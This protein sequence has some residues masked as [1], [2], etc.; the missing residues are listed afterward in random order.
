MQAADLCNTAGGGEL[1]SRGGGVVQCR[2]NRR[3][4]GVAPLA[5]PRAVDLKS[6]PRT[7]EDHAG[8]HEL[9]GRQGARADSTVVQVGDE[10]A[11][12]VRQ[13]CRWQGA[14]EDSPPALDCRAA[15]RLTGSGGGGGGGG[16]G[17]VWVHS[18]RRFLPWLFAF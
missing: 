1:V 14:R 17:K 5:F 11:S 18:R 16:G 8:I 7:A 10:G 12:P 15:T 2:C 9:R 3:R 6:T 4:D 13:G